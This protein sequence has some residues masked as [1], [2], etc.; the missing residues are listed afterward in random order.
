MLAHTH[1]TLMNAQRLAQ[2]LS[3]S[4][5]TVAHYLDLMKDLLLLRRLQPWSS[6]TGKRLVKSPKIYL[7]D[8]GL[9]HALLNL[10]TMDDVLA[11]PVAGESWEGFAIEA[12]IAAAPP[13]ARFYFYRSAVGQ[14]I[15][16]V[17]EFSAARRWAIE[18]KKSSAPVLE[19]GF[20]IAAT[21]IEAKR[22][23]LVYTGDEAYRTGDV[24]VMPLLKAIDAVASGE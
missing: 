16:L 15:D 18:F 10:P 24:E 8:S 1:G 14:E 6:N 19:R 11:H 9:L 21:D 20:H 4:W 23:L 22:R 3:V 13:G 12:V 17:L 5:H 7:R 2:S